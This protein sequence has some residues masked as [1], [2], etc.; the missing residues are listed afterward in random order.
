MAS[1]LISPLSLEARPVRTAGSWLP[2]IALLVSIFVP[3]H[4]FGWAIEWAWLAIVTLLGGLLI[5]NQS[6]RTT[7]LGLPA[8]IWLVIHAALTAAS[9][10]SIG[11]VMFRY[12][13]GLEARDVV[14][15]LRFPLYGLFGLIVAA[16][17]S[18]WDPGAIDRIIRL[19][20]WFVLVC[21]A[22]FVLEAP[23]I[24]DLLSV[25]YAEAKV[26]VGLGVVR[27]PF[28][29]ENPN[30][31]GFF[32]IISL[33]YFT[34]YTPSALYVALLI[35]V[36][37][38]T[39]SRSA[40]IAALPILCLGGVVTA[41]RFSV[42][43]IGIRSIVTWALPFIVTTLLAIF[44]DQLTYFS[45]LAELASALQG[46][47]GVQ[48]A[49]V[50]FELAGALLDWFERSPMLGW[51]PGRTLGL[52]VADNQYVSWLVN[53]GLVGTALAVAANLLLLGRLAL[54]AQNMRELLGA[55]ALTAALALMIFT[56]DFL[57][58]YRLYFVMLMM[59]QACF[60]VATGSNMSSDAGNRFHEC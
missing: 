13:I 15:L 23:I 45:R 24:F 53:W 6:N 14:E 48:T 11:W 5:L 46:G 57:E 44:W 27:V 58:N 56:G 59:L 52:D 42:D 60:A 26:L 16:L 12:H 37:F 3:G 39:G 30:F 4:M 20:P 25:I 29:F 2:A 34:F 7:L 18:R 38:V 28:P 17:A 1:N 55:I 21:T 32:A 43:E 54:I 49:D 8:S 33:A 50:R 47:R 35:V 51:G 10:I 41:W 22:A 40:W 31:L 19:L 36:L 9:V